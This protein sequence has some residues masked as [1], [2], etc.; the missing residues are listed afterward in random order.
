MVSRPFCKEDRPDERISVTNDLHLDKNKLI[1]SF[2]ILLGQYNMAGFNQKA[3]Q[4]M[5]RM[6]EIGQSRL[7]DLLLFKGPNY[8]E[9]LKE[10]IMDYVHNCE[11]FLLSVSFK[12]VFPAT[13]PAA[14]EIIGDKWEEVETRLNSMLPFL[15]KQYKN[16]TLPWP[17]FRWNWR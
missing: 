6:V 4:W 16:L 15:V 1:E 9:N 13:I 3:K 12:K 10:Y 5:I 8:Y 2:S 14:A 7:S 17:S 11:S